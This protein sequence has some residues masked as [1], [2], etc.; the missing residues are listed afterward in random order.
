[1]TTVRAVFQTRNQT[2]DKIC[3]PNSHAFLDISRCHRV[4]QVHDKLGELF[5]VDD[6]FRIVGVGVDD[7]RAPSD[8]KRLL[9][10]KRLL[11]G[12]QVPQ[13][14]RCETRVRLLDSG[15]LVHTLDHS[16]NI[17][18]YELNTLRVLTLALKILAILVCENLTP[19]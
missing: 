13:S 15:Q 4:S 10:L 9:I 18:F 7:F 1:M 2:Y 11:V 3:S 8:L 6:V 16:L 5:D 19:I 12:G 17:I 14:G